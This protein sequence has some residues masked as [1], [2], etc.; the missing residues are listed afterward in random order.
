MKSRLFAC[1]A[2]ALAAAGL[3]FS[4]AADIVLDFEGEKTLSQAL[5]DAGFSLAAVNGGDKKS[6]IIQKSGTGTLV[7]DTAIPNYVASKWVI[8]NGVVYCKVINAFG[9]SS[10]QVAVRSGATVKMATNVV[11]LN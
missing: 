4:A 10:V 3:V 2:A 6:S 8:N 11:N 7:L 1:C 5:T 9:A